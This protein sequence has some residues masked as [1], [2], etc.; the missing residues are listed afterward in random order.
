[1]ASRARNHFYDGRSRP[2]AIDIRNRDGSDLKPHVDWTRLRDFGR[3]CAARQNGFHLDLLC[4]SDAH[5]RFVRHRAENNCT[6]VL[7][8]PLDC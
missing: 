7:A 6:K 4:V 1:M 2:G 8:I 5:A 3:G